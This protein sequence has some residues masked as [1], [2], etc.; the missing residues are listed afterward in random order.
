MYL[1][2]KFNFFSCYTYAYPCP[3]Q[4]AR[5]PASCRRSPKPSPSQPRKPAPADP[6]H[7]APWEFEYPNILENYMEGKLVMLI[8]QEK[9]D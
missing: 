7:K 1:T 9:F 5:S 2:C 4:A 3:W 8:S 6:T